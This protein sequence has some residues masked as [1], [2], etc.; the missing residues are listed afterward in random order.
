MC[1]YEHIRECVY[2][3]VSTH[4][5]MCVCL[6]VYVCVCTHMCMCVLRHPKLR[7]MQ[8]CDWQ[9]LSVDV[10]DIL[11]ECD[12]SGMPWAHATLHICSTHTVTGKHLHGGTCLPLLETPSFYLGCM[13]IP[14]ATSH[15]SLWP[16]QI[17]GLNPPSLGNLL[18]DPDIPLPRLFPPG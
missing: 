9:L 7:A 14:Q 5:C 17:L 3:C 6:C 12:I 10:S 15:H 2:V 18:E 11:P 13:A 8:G 1:V 16:P 4:M